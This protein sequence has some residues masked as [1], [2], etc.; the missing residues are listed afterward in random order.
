MRD[1]PRDVRTVKGNYL[2]NF[3]L[4]AKDTIVEGTNS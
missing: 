1:P 4:L 2:L 3:N